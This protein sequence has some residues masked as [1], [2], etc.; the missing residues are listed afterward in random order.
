ME[1]GNLKVAPIG[2]TIDGGTLALPGLVPLLADLPTSITY[3]TSIFLHHLSVSMYQ[4]CI[5]VG[6]G[7]WEITTLSIG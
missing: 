6:Y 1:A 2:A 4:D 7:C 3:L 5:K